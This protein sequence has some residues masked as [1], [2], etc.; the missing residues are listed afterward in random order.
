MTRGA[1]TGI[2]PA[3]VS[4]PPPHF[5]DRRSLLLGP[6]DAQNVRSRTQ[7]EPICPFPLGEAA[8]GAE[9]QGAAES[10]VGYLCFWIVFEEV[11][12]MNLAVIE[13]MRH[14][15]D[16]QIPSHGR[17][18]TGLSQSRPSRPARSAGIQPRRAYPLSRI[19]GFVRQP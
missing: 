17:L 8:G 12:L 16:R 4:L 15:G 19:S 13:S 9:E 14:R 6:L 18:Q 5:E 1:W 7:R 11:R 3:T 10:I 2:E